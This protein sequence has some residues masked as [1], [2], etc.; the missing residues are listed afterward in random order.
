[1]L[2][3]L[4]IV[5]P[6]IFLILFS[7]P[8]LYFYFLVYHSV[9]L[10]EIPEIKQI[11][12]RFAIAIPA[13]DE[14]SVIGETIKAIKNCD[15]P[16]D[17]IDVYVVADHCSDGT[18]DAAR[19]AGAICYEREEAPQGS[20][21]AAINWLLDMIWKAGIAYE[22]VLFFDADNRPDR[23]FLKT[24]HA[25]LQA[26]KPF[27]QGRVRVSNPEDGWYPALIEAIETVDGRLNQVSRT[28]LGLSAKISGYGFGVKSSV[29]RDNPFP[30]GLTEDYEYRL[31][32]ITKGINVTYEPHAI[33]YTEAA[34]SWQ[35][36]KQQHAR[37]R[38]G[39][40]QNLSD[41]RKRLLSLFLRT[42]S[43]VFLD[44]F[45]QSVFP[46]YST[47]IVL[48]TFILFIQGMISL[49]LNIQYPGWL[50]LSWLVVLCALILYPI[51][52]LMLENA[53][54]RAYVAVFSG[55][56]FVALRTWWAIKSKLFGKKTIWVR[57]ARR[58]K[59]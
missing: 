14:E 35:I 43:A 26:G 31:H 19:L 34:V 17:L 47:L 7:I 28:N 48:T 46:S 3:N 52:G 6:T 4:V 24:I 11:N 12:G 41:Y 37:W 33:V 1:M 27:V 49:T 20:K 50:W 23:E 32:L 51:F 9:R 36:A 39:I 8:I 53:P 5:I 25:A 56:I 21:G 22:A 57:T 15:Y 40:Y 10:P 18:A 54:P 58:T 44:A 38:S 30:T 29:L 59:T 2:N 55:P 42:H 16:I 45:L 13:H